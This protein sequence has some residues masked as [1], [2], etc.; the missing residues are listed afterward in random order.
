LIV[1]KKWY[2]LLVIED[3]VFPPGK[4][5]R[6]IFLEEPLLTKELLYAKRSLM[7]KRLYRL[8]AS[9]VSAY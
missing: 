2:Q 8:V 7:K 5:R 9:Y 4:A 3:E 1:L 6:N